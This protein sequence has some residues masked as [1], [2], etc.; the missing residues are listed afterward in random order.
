MKL[1]EIANQIEE[2]KKTMEILPTGVPAID[3]DL[4]GGFLKRELIVLGGRT[5]A[6]KSL[7][8]GNIFLNIAKLG[9]RCAYF[10]LEISN[11]MIVSRL[12]GA[13]SKI[14]PTRV[15]IKH[16]EGQELDNK[17][18]AKAE[19]TPY[20]EF[21]YFHDDLYEL[22]KIVNMIK[23]EKYD[24]VVIDFLQNILVK[25]DEY[26]RLSHTALVLQRLAKEVNC[27][28]LA[29]SQLSNEVN[30][31]K[32]TDIIEYK[33]SGSIATACDL[34]FFIEPGETGFGSLILRLRKNRRGISGGSYPI[35]IE[36]P[37]GKMIT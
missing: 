14:S 1:S 26:E 32:K 13:G 16:L 7:I 11:D 23:A 31:S 27:C 12:I 3:R 21:M 35:E 36:Y 17:N 8:A 10:S 30:R 9:H 4:E 6:G 33:G 20:E 37:G 28:I 22:E 5:G 34:G 25:G 19:L 29:L 15:M 2:N 24:F 18:R